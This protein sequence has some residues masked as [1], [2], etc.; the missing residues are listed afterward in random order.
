MWWLGSKWV[1]ENKILEKHSK[2][3][4]IVLTSAYFDNI[5][6]VVNVKNQRVNFLL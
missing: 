4:S 2:S 1:N 5:H 6:I 3:D